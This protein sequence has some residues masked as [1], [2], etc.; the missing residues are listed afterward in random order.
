MIE[1]TII[2]LLVVLTSGA[3]IGGS[4]YIFK[5]I[6]NKNKKIKDS[7]GRPKFTFLDWILLIGSIIILVA[8][9]KSIFGEEDIIGAFIGSIFILILVGYVAGNK[10][11]K[12]LKNK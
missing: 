2:N 5:L 1:D 12:L 6:S 9:L 4:A 10:L 8:F 7:T 3:V 11:Y